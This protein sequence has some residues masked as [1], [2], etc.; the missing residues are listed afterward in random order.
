[1]FIQRKLEI[2]FFHISKLSLFFF[3]CLYTAKVVEFAGDNRLGWTMTFY[4]TIV[5][6]TIGLIAFL[7]FAD[8]TPQKWAISQV[9][10]IN[11]ENEQSKKAVEEKKSVSNN[12]VVQIP[13]TSDK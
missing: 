13:V 12:I 6:Y 8:S 1:V 9:E 7:L 10:E 11:E 2:I 4:I 5:I 3:K